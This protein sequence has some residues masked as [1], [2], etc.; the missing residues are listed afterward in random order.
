MV[1]I[2]D[3]VAAATARMVRRTAGHKVREDIPSDLAFASAD[4]L[5]LEQA[6]VNLLDN[7]VKYSPA[8]SEILVAVRAMDDRIVLTVED[9]GP[10]IPLSELPHIFD[11]FYRVRKADHGVAGTGLGLSVARGFV[12]SFGGS[13]AAGNRSDR[14]GAIFTLTIP[15][16]KLQSAG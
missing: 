4:P 8:G 6:L 5:L 2:S 9:E 14:N 10:G 16:N 13:L 7:A 12:E 11:K 15:V 3:A 1:D